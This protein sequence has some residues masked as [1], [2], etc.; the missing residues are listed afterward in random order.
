MVKNYLLR[1]EYL[2][3]LCI[4]I[5]KSNLFH[6]IISPALIR[7]GDLFYEGHG[8]RQKDMFSAAEMY[9]QAALRNEPQVGSF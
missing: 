2:E 8:D 9:K 4:N 3:T 5:H 1:L 7:M 6:S